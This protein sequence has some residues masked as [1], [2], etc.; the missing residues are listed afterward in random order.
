MSLKYILCP[1]TGGEEDGP[2]LRLALQVAAGFEAHVRALFVRSSV[3]AA[4]PYLGEGLTGAVVEN[5]V[6]AAGKASDE[7]LVAA[8]Q[9]VQKA[10]AE[11]KVPEG[12]LSVRVTAA[13]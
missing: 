10:V 7:S 11:A 2:A 3:A 12:A 6:A 9:H 1:V 4:I 8:N 13:R 5:I